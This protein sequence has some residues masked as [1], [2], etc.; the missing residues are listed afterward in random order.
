T[1]QNVALFQRMSVLDNVLVGDHARVANNTFTSALKLGRGRH[2]EREAT[3]RA[4]AA[5]D[6]VGLKHLARAYCAG[7]PFP[8]QKRVELAR[9]LVSQPQLL[10]LDEPAGGLTQSEVRDLSELI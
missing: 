4:L 7:L 3:E 10:L 1:F 8:V 5:L 9:A 2:A 6:V